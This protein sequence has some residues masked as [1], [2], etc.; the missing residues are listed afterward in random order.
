MG[1]VQRCLLVSVKGVKLAWAVRPAPSGWGFSLC[2]DNTAALCLPLK[3]SL[4]V[5]ESKGASVYPLSSSA[6]PVP[7]HGAHE[8]SSSP[9]L[10]LPE[11]PAR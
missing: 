2:E 4:E 9:L 7:A 10:L 1:D 8:E 6:N 3:K 5:Q 11:A